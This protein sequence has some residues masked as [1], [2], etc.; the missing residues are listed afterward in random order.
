MRILVIE[1]NAYKL[2]TIKNLLKE[3]EEIKYDVATYAVEAF[4]FFFQNQYDLIILDLGL[5]RDDNDS[6]RTYAAK[7]GMNLLEAIRIECKHQKKE[8]PD[9]IVFS[10]TQLSDS[11]RLGVFG[12]ANDEYD[13]RK[14]FQNWQELKQTSQFKILIVEDEEQKLRRVQNALSKFQKVKYMHAKCAKEAI[15]ICKQDYDIDIMILDMCFPWNIDGKANGQNGIKLVK[16]LEK[17]YKQQRNK[18]PK[19]IVF[20]TIAFET[21]ILRAGEKLPESFYGQTFFQSGL[22]ELLKAVMKQNEK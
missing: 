21:A 8:M 1:D 11:E 10:K 13:L 2:R 20:S 6:F 19:I 18:M 5:C 7:Q 16:E 9:V 12:K 15:D 22:E 4:K 14:L 17:L 3:R